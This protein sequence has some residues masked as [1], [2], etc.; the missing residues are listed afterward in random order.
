MQQSHIVNLEKNSSPRFEHIECTGNKE[1]LGSVH[2][3]TSWEE[4]SR[5]GSSSNFSTEDVTVERL[6]KTP[7]VNRH[8]P[9]QKDD[10]P[11]DQRVTQEAGNEQ[12]TLPK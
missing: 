6:R 5:A 8:P 12:S 9:P 1:L 10:V 7:S 2:L 4:T 11:F 3:M